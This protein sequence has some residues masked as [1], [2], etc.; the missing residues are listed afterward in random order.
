MDSNLFSFLD[1]NLFLEK[2]V[3]G[4][5]FEASLLLSSFLSL[6]FKEFL[7]KLG[8]CRTGLAFLLPNPDIDRPCASSVSATSV[9]TSS[10][11]KDLARAKDLE[12]D[13]NLGFS[14]SVSS[15]STNLLVGF[16]L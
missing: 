2:L 11:S 9:N 15:S 7:L 5:K 12:R 1:L 16:V 8:R 6:I 13:L 4:L 14:V 3:L 10:F